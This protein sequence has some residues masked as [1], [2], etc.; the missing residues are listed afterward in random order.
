MRH[1]PLT[2]LLLPLLCVRHAVSQFTTD[3][4]TATRTAG[5]VEPTSTVI[6][7]PSPPTTTSGYGAT[8]SFTIDTSASIISGFGAGSD[9]ACY[10]LCLAQAAVPNGCGVTDTNCQCHNSA[11]TSTWEACLRSTCSSTDYPRAESMLLFTCSNLTPSFFSITSG[12][13]GFTTSTSPAATSNQAESS[14]NAASASV[15]ELNPAPSSNTPN[16][17]TLQSS[18]ASGLLVLSALVVL[19]GWC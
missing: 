5:I 15:A 16:S 19:A 2:F 10:A 7:T 8:Y 18:A 11:V 9:P 17:A 6:L 14:S 1:S 13:A 3:E 12:S 4:A